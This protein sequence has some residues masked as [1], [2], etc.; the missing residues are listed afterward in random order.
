MPASGPKWP[1]MARDRQKGKEIDRQAPKDRH[2]QTG[3]DRQTGTQRRKQA[4]RDGQRQTDRSR[5]MP[6]TIIIFVYSRSPAPAALCYLMFDIT[7]Y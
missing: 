3:T 2:R 1:E 7:L 6:Y 4:D 5:Q